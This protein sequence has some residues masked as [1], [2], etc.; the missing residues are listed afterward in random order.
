MKINH[1]IALR[2][3]D[4]FWH[5]IE[6]LG[7][8][9]ERGSPDN[10]LRLA[11]SVLNVTEDHAQ[12][13]EVERLLAKY[14][15]A[16]H[17]VSNKFT[18]AELG[19]AEWLELSALGHHGYPQPE[20]DFGYKEATYDVSDACRICGIG[21]VQNA[22]FR[23]RSEFK[24]S[25]S[26]VVQLNWVFDEFFLRPEAC[27]GLLGA[28]ITGIDFLAPVIHKN[29]RPSEQVAQ[30][31]VKT[32]LPPALD[33]TGLEPVTCKPQNEEWQALQ[34]LIPSRPAPG[35]HCGG[36]YCGRIKYHRMRKGPFRFGR[37]AFAGAPD[38][39]KSHEW[40][41]SGGAAFRL[42][43]VSQ[44]FRQCFVAAKWRGVSFEPIE[45]VK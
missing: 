11:I 5:H 20:R 14:G 17:S 41:G 24:A 27:D 25:H 2:H 21:R 6:R 30:M 1:R 38:V 18:K 22:P 16:T 12:W 9:Y 40:F 45:L 15:P 36:P 31:I 42:V 44:R 34:R 13:P 37:N 28:A 8:D 19:A 7:L 3:D 29:D 43:L 23:L 32:T 4:P 33:P 10:V 26:Q 39:V 35:P